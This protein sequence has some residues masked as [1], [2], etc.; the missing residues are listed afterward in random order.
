MKNLKI[1]VLFCLIG[2]CPSCNNDDENYSEFNGTYHEISPVKNRTLIEFTS[3]TDLTIIKSENTIDNFKYEI[4]GNT[5]I[6]THEP[7]DQTQS[8]E[9]EKIGKNEFRI[10]NLYADI[11]ENGIT[12]ITFKKS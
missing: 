11:P 3:S 2:L 8:L 7:S 9:F 5:I 12:F 1:I 4:N 10:Q 6:L